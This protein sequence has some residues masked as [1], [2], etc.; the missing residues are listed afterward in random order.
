MK[1]KYASQ[2]KYKASHKEQ[3]KGYRDK[4]EASHTRLMIIIPSTNKP[5]IEALKGATNKSFTEI[6][7]DAILEKYKVDIL[8]VN[9]DE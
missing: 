1:D 5:T 2:N 3:Y 9:D 8:E 4:Y 7:R 6:V